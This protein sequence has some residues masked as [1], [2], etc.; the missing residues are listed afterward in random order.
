MEKR[1]AGSYV[2]AFHVFGEAVYH[3]RQ[4]CLVTQYNGNVTAKLVP[5]I[6]FKPVVNLSRLHILSGSADECNVLI[7][8]K[9]M[10]YV[11]V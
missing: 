8:F 1:K 11:G 5:V 10:I 3:R 9:V 6:L 4:Q 2:Y 7:S